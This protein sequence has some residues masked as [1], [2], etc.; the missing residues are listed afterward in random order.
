M[1][2]QRAAVA[3]GDVFVS[4]HALQANIVARVGVLQQNAVTHDCAATDV[5]TTEQDRVFHRSLNDASV[6]DQRACDLGAGGIFGGRAVVQPK[7]QGQNGQSD[8]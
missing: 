2:C 8:E 4:N 1:T 7:K 6:G 3:N 5:D